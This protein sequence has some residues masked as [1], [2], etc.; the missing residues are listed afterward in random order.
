MCFI[1]INQSYKHF[2]NKKR[3][4]FQNKQNNQ[5]Q[6]IISKQILTFTKFLRENN[7]LNGN[8]LNQLMEQAITIMKIS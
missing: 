2:L 7:D 8:S 5:L 6:D 3:L 1:N 4:Q